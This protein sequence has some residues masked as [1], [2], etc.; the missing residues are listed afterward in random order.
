MKIRFAI[1]AAVFVALGTWAFM[2]FHSPANSP[3][4]GQQSREIKSLSPT[5][6]EELRRG[7]GWGLAKAAELNG[8]P[9]PKH[10]L[11]MKDEIALS[12]TQVDEITQVFE[13][14]RSSAKSLGEQ[15]IERERVLEEQFREGTVNEESLTTLLEDIAKVRTQLR[16]AHLSAHLKT[17]EIVSSD[18]IEQYN[19]LR[20]YGSGNPCAN[21]PKG[22]NAAMWR[23]HNGCS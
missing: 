10:L 13:T 12:Q 6:I 17:P 3:Y 20:G 23:K 2:H 4:A 21:V 1:V 19:S 14:M 8:V 11:E 9:G 16:F 22:H 7:G 18:Q 5:D 15:L